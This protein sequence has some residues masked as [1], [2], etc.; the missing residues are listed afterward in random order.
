MLRE[1]VYNGVYFTGKARVFSLAIRECA[2]ATAIANQICCFTK[3]LAGVKLTES[4][5][6][7]CL[8]RH[9]PDH[10]LMFVCFSLM[11]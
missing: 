11:W 7:T 10:S 2:S 9:L 5:S 6:H 4:V 1:R 3:I 8:Q